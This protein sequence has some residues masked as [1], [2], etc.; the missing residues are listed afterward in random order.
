MSRVN[1]V[2]P[3]AVEGVAVQDPGGFQGLHVLVGDFD[4]AGIDA[5]VE[6]G[7][8]G[9]SGG[10]GDGLEGFDDDLVGFQWSSAPV[11]AD[12]G[13]QPVFDLV[14]LA[15]AGR[16]VADGDRQAGLGG[17]LGEF[18]SSTVGVVTRSNHRSR[19]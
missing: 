4:A 17:E 19:R 9:Q 7:V 18:G 8:H 14:P 13:E 12:R 2:V 3:V 5:L 15:G 6:F 11:T 1:R 16:E 10:R